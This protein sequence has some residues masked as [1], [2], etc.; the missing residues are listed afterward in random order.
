MA[1]RDDFLLE[2]KYRNSIDSVIS[3]YVS[4][5]KRGNNL[6]GLCPFHNEKTPS[7]TLYP[8]NGSFYCFGCHTG[9]DVISFIMKIENLDYMNAVKLLAE[10]SSLQMPV[11]D[12]YDDRMEKLKSEVVKANKLAAKFF[13]ARLLD[14]M[15]RETREYLTGR[16]LSV[17]TVRA[18]GIGY[19]PDS[20]DM[21]YKYLRS[22]N[23]SDDAIF[24]AN[25]CGKGKNGKMYDRFR[26]R[27]MFP[28]IDVRGNVVAFSGRNLP[29]VES[30]GK[31]VNTSE[32]CVYKKG[33]ML[34][35]LN[36][37]KNYCS[38][39]AIL[40]EGNLDVIAMHQAGFQNTVGSLGTAFTPNQARLIS[41]YTK[42]IVV[43]LD[44]DKA[45]E[46]ATDKVIPILS[47]AN[48]NIRIL[49]LP[50]CKDPDEYLK[51][52]SAERLR[53]LIDGART[54]IEYMLLK[55]AEGLDTSL[56]DA[57]ITYL[58]RASDILAGVDNAIAV[59][60]YAGKLADIYKISKQT[61]L[62]SIEEARKKK[63]TQQTKSELKQIVKIG[64]R[65]PVNPEKSL[66]KKA[67]AAEETICS[68]L[69]Y[70]PDLYD[71][72]KDEL[73]CEDFVTS[74]NRKLYEAIA[75]IYDRN[76]HFDISLLGDGFSADELGAVVLLQAQKKFGEKPDE[77]IKD[78]VK[79]LK[80]EKKRIAANA[81]N[82]EDDDWQSQIS[83][84]INSKK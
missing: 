29:G 55:A 84:I 18:F 38:E 61:L 76:I 62:I 81:Q 12:A 80:A 71:A 64:E 77:L 57:K 4:L 14:D 67:A 10:R 83:G 53:A 19:A 3:N 33:D 73:S 37:A 13:C 63:K 31:Y 23:I 42:E 45:G 69:M 24:E 79:V 34:F 15:G 58:R 49:R 50:D 35:G 32:T 47:E 6:I 46:N 20:W 1:L 54:D 41:R 59:D 11:D 78:C 21:L 25:L 27:V 9:G 43:M 8:E 16:G 65:D 70:H 36:V 17:K 56:D 22:Q 52:Y 66:H 5:K 68:V 74:F 26:N 28:I 60:L 75:G 39:R 30:G 82:G 40:V 48:V 2:L 44:A 72:I 51:K 7:F